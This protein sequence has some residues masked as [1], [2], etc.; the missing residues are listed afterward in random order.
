MHLEFVLLNFLRILK[1]LTCT[2]MFKLYMHA[3]MAWSKD[4]ENSHRWDLAMT[5]TV[6][7]MKQIFFY[8]PE[9]N[10][11]IFF[12]ISFLSTWLLDKH[13]TLRDTSVAGHDDEYTAQSHSY[14]II[15]ISLAQQVGVGLKKNVYFT[16]LLHFC[17]KHF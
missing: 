1:I 9:P 15:S 2:C 12:P 17:L 11:L 5:L 10:C 14:G 4:K 13:V 8:H 6:S 3:L 16:C 7:K